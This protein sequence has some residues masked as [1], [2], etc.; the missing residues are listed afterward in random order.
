[1]LS[2]LS[3]KYALLLPGKPQLPIVSGYFG[4]VAHFGGTLQ[5]SHQKKGTSSFAAKMTLKVP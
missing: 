1:M 5:F 4:L 2:L 3:C